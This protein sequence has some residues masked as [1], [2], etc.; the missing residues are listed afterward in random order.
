MFCLQ[1]LACIFSIIACLSGNDELQEAS[2]RL[3][4]FADLTYCTLSTR[5]KWI[6]EMA[7]LS[8]SP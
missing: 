5:L 8:H 7:S 6:K 2:Q 4:C 3:N 1:Q